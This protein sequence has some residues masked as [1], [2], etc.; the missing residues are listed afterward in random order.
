MVLLIFN[1]K[2][3]AADSTLGLDVACLGECDLG[4]IRTKDL[5]DKN[6]KE[7]DGLYNLTGGCAKCKS[8]ARH[9][10]SNARL[11]KKGYAKVLGGVLIT[12]GHTRADACAEILTN[13]S[14]RDVDNADKNEDAVSEYGEVE[15]CTADNEEEHEKGRCPLVRSV[16]KIL[17]EVTDVAENS[18]EH[19]TSEQGRECDV[20][21]TYVDADA[22]DSNGS[23]YEGN[24]D[25]HTL[26]VGVEVSLTY[27][28][29]YAHDRTECDRKHNLENG[30]D[31]HGNNVNDTGVNGLGDAEGNREYDKTYRVV[32]SN[33]GKEEVGERALCLILLY[34][35]ESCG[36][37]GRG[38]YCA[39]NDSGGKGKHVIANDEGEGDENDI[40]NDA[41][42][43]RL[44]DTD[45]GSLAADLL[46]LGNSELVTDRKGDEAK[47]EVAKDLV[48]VRGVV[49]GV[50]ADAKSSE[51]EGSDEDARNEICGNGG[52][53][54][55]LYNSGE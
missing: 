47:S 13:A 8:L 51:K 28:E 39:E 52:K 37:S 32:K 27:C 11:R 38:S 34:N 44:E 12:V 35:H 2:S 3:S 43:E 26:G 25:S 6:R 49:G 17:G 30:I 50:K 24:G 42:E 31:K 55:E 9:T 22:G 14:E 19:H 5:V 48:V 45:D 4:K 54:K 36:R 20:N 7:C 29:E 40:H 41:G 23:H 21:R 10:E 46:E 33:Y 18:T 1:V 16:H 53:S 15:L